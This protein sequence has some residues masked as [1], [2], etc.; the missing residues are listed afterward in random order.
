MS[1]RYAFPKLDLLIQL[2]TTTLSVSENYSYDGA[3]SVYLLSLSK[4]AFDI[5]VALVAISLLSPL[6]IM[7]AVA[8]AVTSPGPILFR[9][10]RYGL[11]MKDFEILKFRTMYY[12]AAGA[13][14][15]QAVRGDARITPLGRILRKSSLDELPQLFNVIQGTM[16]IIGPSPHP[17]ALDEQYGSS[18][19][20]YGVRF[21]ARP[22][23][24]GLA[25]ISGARGE[26]ASVEQMSRRIELDVQYVSRA[27]L[28]LDAVILF[29]T[30]F[31][32]VGSR[33]AF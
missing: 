30:A 29:K 31:E 8:I 23:I 6:L 13:S 15:V 32:V 1:E 12:S 24:T 11:G 28:A 17:I 10:R 18:I 21:E 3:Q 19:G 5:I 4:R 22:G 33:Q 27:S 7:I 20:F 14:F 16:S 2:R 9:Q 25:Q 26:T